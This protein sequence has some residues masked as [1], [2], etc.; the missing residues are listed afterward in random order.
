MRRGTSRSEPEWGVTEAKG[1]KWHCGIVD[2]TR[3]TPAERE[4][5]PEGSKGGT[6]RERPGLYEGAWRI[7]KTREEARQ[8][9]RKTTGLPPREGKGRKTQTGRLQ[10]ALNEGE[11]RLAKSREDGA[12]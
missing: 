8:A 9:R 2:G 12:R 4:N 10:D 5:T 6:K 11:C 7:S 1:E 3:K